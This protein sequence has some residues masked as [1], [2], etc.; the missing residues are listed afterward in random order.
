[1]GE[2][3]AIGKTALPVLLDRAR[4]ALAGATTAAEIL[5]ARDAASLAYDV[6]KRAARIAK[7]KDAHSTVVDAAHHAQADALEIEATADQRLADEYDAAQERGEIA[8]GPVRTDLVPAGNQERPATSKQIGVSK[9][10]IYN[11]RKVRDAEAADPGVVKRTLDAIMATGTEP[12]KA[13]LRRSIGG[14]V[15]TMRAE[16][17]AAKKQRRA[18]READLGGRIVRAAGVL[19]G[20]PKVYGVLYADPAW[21]FEPWSRESGLDRDASNHYPTRPT[22]VLAALQ[23]PAAPSSVLFLWA[24]A[25]MLPDALQVMSAW[26]FTYKSNAVWRKDRMSTGYWFRFYHEHL[27]VGVRG[28]VPAPAPGEQSVSVIDAMVGDHSV[29]PAIFHDLIEKMFPILPK[30]EMFARSGRPGWDSWGAE[31]PEQEA[32]E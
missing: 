4:K 27:L 21:Q 8:S 13:R 1:M 15:K 24:I 14:V 18:E 32:A 17:T 26:G 3:V 6:A 2:V 12:T 28:D 31:A 20:M 5:E 7:A 22:D 16:K 9:K 11:A 25:P 23:P 19:A 29:K 10:Q 30:L